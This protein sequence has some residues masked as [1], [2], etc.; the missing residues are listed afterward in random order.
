MPEQAVAKASPLIF[1]AKA[2]VI[3]LLQQAAP[4]ILVPEQAFSPPAACAGFVIT[5]R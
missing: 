4:C 1:L 5:S 3:D 2:R